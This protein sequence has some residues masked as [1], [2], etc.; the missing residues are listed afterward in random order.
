MAV[1]QLAC[2]AMSTRE[3]TG[4]QLLVACVTEKSMFFV[5][6]SV[7]FSAPPPLFRM[8]AKLF[9]AFC[10]QRFFSAI[11][12]SDCG[13]L[14]TCSVVFGCSYLQ[15]ADECFG[16]NFNMDIGES[17]AAWKRKRMRQRLIASAR[18]CLPVLPFLLA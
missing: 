6:S 13:R 1:I 17:I 3:N 11:L 18:M 12:F 2:R 5:Y 7:Y 16:A 14:R 9:V 15:A 10:A 8:T 4:A